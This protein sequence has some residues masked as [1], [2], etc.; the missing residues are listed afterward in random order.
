MSSVLVGPA[1]TQLH[2]SIINCT[3]C[4]LRADWIDAIAVVEQ[5]LKVGQTGRSIL[6]QVHMS[7]AGQK[8]PLVGD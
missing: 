4:G 1:V 3:P 5:L 6:R 8:W 7:G 2:D